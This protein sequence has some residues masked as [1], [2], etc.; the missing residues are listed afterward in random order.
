MTDSEKILQ[1]IKNDITDGN[2][3]R[4]SNDVNNALSNNIKPQEIIDKSIVEAMKEIGEKF[5]KGI[6]FV[7][8]L[9]LAGEIAKEAFNILLPL[10]TGGSDSKKIGKVLIGTVEGDVHDIGKNL[11]ATMLQGN[12]FEVIDV[13]VDVSPERFIEEAKLNNPDIVAMS[14]LISL[15]MNAIPRTIREFEK[16]GTRGRYKFLVGGAVINERFARESGADAY[17]DNAYQAVVE[18][19]KLLGLS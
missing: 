3:E 7:P 5:D 18:A 12:G 14:N 6:C 17:G 2:Y 11:V 16:S 19:K 4:I 15:T 13:G 9:L 10:M 8:E 1:A